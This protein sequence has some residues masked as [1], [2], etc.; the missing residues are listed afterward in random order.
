V[1]RTFQ[2]IFESRGFSTDWRTHERRRQKILSHLADELVA[3]GPDEALR[4]LS[5]LEQEGCV[6]LARRP[7][8]TFLVYQLAQ[9]AS[10][11][12]EWLRAGIF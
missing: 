7:R 4:R 3:L 1:D 11:V 8:S 10:D 2:R 5:D 12:V 6:R 9:R